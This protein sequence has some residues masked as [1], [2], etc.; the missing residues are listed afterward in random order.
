MFITQVELVTFD[1]GQDVDDEDLDLVRQVPSLS[2][3]GDLTLHPSDLSVSLVDPIP[4]DPPFSLEPDTVDMTSALNPASPADLSPSL[5]PMGH[6]PLHITPTS[7]RN[8]PVHLS[9]SMENNPLDLS[10]D[11]AGSPLHIPTSDFLL[12]LHGY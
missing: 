2:V 4:D 6:S 3:V 5:Q 11:L 12:T 9:P 10:P 1:E 8:S 7:L